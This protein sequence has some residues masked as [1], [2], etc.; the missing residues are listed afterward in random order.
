MRD[1]LLKLLEELKLT[2]EL[3]QIANRIENLFAGKEQPDQMKLGQIIHMLSEDFIGDEYIVVDK[4]YRG[5]SGITMSYGGC[6]DQLAIA[7]CSEPIK[8][9]ELL[10]ELKKTYS[11]EY[12]G[13]KGG[14]YQMTPSTPVWISPY[15]E[16]SDLYITGFE[17][18]GNLAVIRTGVEEW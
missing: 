18:V 11:A 16:V 17:K 2:D 1:K 4:K 7:P 15:G 14:R 10:E 13:Y 8:V 3:D 9:S 12:E 6:Y 5:V